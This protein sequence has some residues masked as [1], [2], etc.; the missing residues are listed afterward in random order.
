MVEL[1]ASFN[2]YP[3]D[4]INLTVDEPDLDLGAASALAKTTAREMDSNAM[5]LSYHSGKTGEF[6]PKYECGGNGRP[7][8]IV[9]A[10]ARGYNLKID[11]NA[12]DYEFFYVRF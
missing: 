7:P 5:M 6:W 1:D 11:I 9:F 2:E 8:W 10:E 12:G 4:T 3:L